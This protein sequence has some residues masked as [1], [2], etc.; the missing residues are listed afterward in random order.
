MNIVQILESS[1]QIKKN[2]EAEYERIRIGGESVRMHVAVKATGKSAKE[3]RALKNMPKE[4]REEKEKK[5]AQKIRE[6]KSK[7]VEVDH[8][9]NQKDSNGKKNLRAMPKKMHTAKT[10]KTRA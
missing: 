9:N 7:N 3:L 1:K 4:E 8:Q 5:L 2:R 6:F 10:N